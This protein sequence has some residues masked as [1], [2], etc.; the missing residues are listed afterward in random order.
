M[1]RHFRNCEE[2]IK[3]IDRELFQSGIR[4]DVKH[5]Q[6]KNL[7]DEDRYTKEIIAV[8]ACINKPLV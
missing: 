7:E 6:D 8:S 3:E 2:Y 1:T 4:V 5:Y